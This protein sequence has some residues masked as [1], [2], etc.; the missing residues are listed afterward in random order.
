[1]FLFLFGFIVVI[2]VC[3]VSLGGTYY[4]TGTNLEASDTKVNNI[5]S[6]SLSTSLSLEY[7]TIT[8]QTSEE[9]CG[10]ICMYSTGGPLRGDKRQQK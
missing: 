10:L 1:M 6:F 3:E 4:N 7:L 9:F 8:V 5:L 2:F